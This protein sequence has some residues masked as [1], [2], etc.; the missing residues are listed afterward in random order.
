MVFDTMT[1]I[2]EGGTVCPKYIL[3]QSRIQ[4]GQLCPS[5][6]HHEDGQYNKLGIL[7]RIALDSESWKQLSTYFN[8]GK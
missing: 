8:A 3:T 5:Q 4:N 2:I 1:H 6:E 7:R